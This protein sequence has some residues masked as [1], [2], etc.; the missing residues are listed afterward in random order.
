MTF[1]LYP[2]QQEDVAY[3]GH[4][5]AVL[6]GHDMGTGKTVIGLDRERLLRLIPRAAHEKGKR[7]TLIVA[8]AGPVVD[9]WLEH[10]QKHLPQLKAMKMDPKNREAFVKDVFNGGH[11]IYIMHWDALRLVPDLARVQWFHVLADEVHR[12]CN[13][14]SQQ[15]QALKRI[16]TYYKTG[17]S[18]TW[19]YDKPD[20]AWSVLNWLYP[21]KFS[22]YWRFYHR[23]VDFETEYRDN[24]QYKKMI[25]VSNAAELQALIKPFYVR[26][27]KKDVLKDLPDKYYTTYWVDLLPQQRI[28]YDEMRKNFL[29][30][31][32]EHQNE[33]VAAPVV[34]SQLVRLQQFACAYSRLDTIMVREHDTVAEKALT[35]RDGKKHTIYKRDPETGEI[36]LVPKQVVRMAEPSSKLDTLDTILEDAGEEQVV[37]F[38]QSK[39]LINLAATRLDK[40]YAGRIAVCTGDVPQEDRNALVKGFQAGDLRVFLGTIKTGGVGITLTAASTVIFLDRTWEPSINIQAEDRLH[41]IGQVNAVQVIDIMAKNTVDLGRWQRLQKKW[42]WIQ[43][44][45]GDTVDERTLLGPDGEPIRPDDEEKK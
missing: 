31:V 39:Q 37:I 40:K 17:L 3:F 35:A 20:Q 1:N 25:G 12:A 14:K 28:A 5:S 33:P 43:L 26:R 41:R 2:Y 8:P 19:T 27:R 42:E 29:A 15:T 44:M 21:K 45:L 7:I 23:Y 22:A 11:S 36:L 32:G 34:I 38:S 16:Q 9:M 24:R 30:W 10:V 13:R 18:G 6:G 4:T